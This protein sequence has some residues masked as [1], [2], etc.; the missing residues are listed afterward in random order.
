M[1]LYRLKGQMFSNLAQCLF[2]TFLLCLYKHFRLLS[3]AEPLDEFAPEFFIIRP[4]VLS[5]FIGTDRDTGA[6][7][8]TQVLI[9]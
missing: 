4:T 9:S 1:S 2:A 7:G 8:N 5:G 3:L 6:A